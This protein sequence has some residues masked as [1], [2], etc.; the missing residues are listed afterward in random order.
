MKRL[1]SAHARSK[2]VT[3][4]ANVSVRNLSKAGLALMVRQTFWRARLA[5]LRRLSCL[6]S[7]EVSKAA[8]RP[9]RAPPPLSTGSS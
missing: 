6:T 5:V 2:S 1:K 3:F 4:S 7:A 9:L 8:A